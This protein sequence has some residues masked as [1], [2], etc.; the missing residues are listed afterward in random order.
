MS[1]LYFRVFDK[2]WWTKCNSCCNLTFF[3]NLRNHYFQPLSKAKKQP[4]TE[5][6]NLSSLIQ[7]KE[8]ASPKKVQE[9]T[10]KVEQLEIKEKIHKK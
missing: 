10:K 6:L 2:N 9:V 8:T 1:F 5:G 7:K 4:K 3:R